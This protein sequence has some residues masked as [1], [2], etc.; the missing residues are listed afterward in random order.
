MTA[1][2]AVQNVQ[3]V[4]IKEKRFA[5]IE[6]EEWEALVEWLETLEDLQVFKESY[7]QLEQAGGNREKAGWLRWE[8]V[9][10]EVE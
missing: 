10:D 7:K 5:V 3:F 1:L 9:R 6:A 2:E 4:T 8:E